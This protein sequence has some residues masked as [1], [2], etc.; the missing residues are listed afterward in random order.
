MNKQVHVH[1]HRATTHDRRAHDAGEFEESK[2]PRGKG[3]QFAKG[4]SEAQAASA[5][6]RAKAAKALENHKKAITEEGKAKF[7]GAHHAH[8][9]AAAWAE[10]G[11]KPDYE[12]SSRRGNQM[13]L[14]AHRAEKNNAA[15]TDEHLGWDKLVKELEAKGHSKESAE[16]I[17]GYI[18]KKKYGGGGK[19]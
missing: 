2:H 15:T 10:A 8:N 13:S 17:A 18:N 5:G 7:M 9:R 4:S 12:L 3:G 14:A 1:I 16:K 11:K 19:H 6:S